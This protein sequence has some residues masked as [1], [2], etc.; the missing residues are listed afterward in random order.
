[1]INTK[2]MSKVLVSWLAF[3][4]DFLKNEQESFLGVDPN[5]THCQFYEH[6]YS[7]RSYDEHILLYSNPRQELWAEHLANTLKQINK[8]SK[9]S[10]R[11]LELKNVVGLDEIKP[12][13]EDLLL[14]LRE[15]EIEIFF[16]PGTSIM[17]LSWVF[18][19][20]TLRLNT[21]L[22]QTI[23][24]KHFDDK[25]PRLEE[26]TFENNLVPQTA[27]IKQQQ[28]EQSKAN[29]G[30]KLTPSIE[31]AYKRAE[32]VAQT[33][34]V[35]VFIRGESGTGKE[36]LARHVH[37]NSARRDAPFIPVNCAA[38]ADSLLESRLFGHKS[39]SFTGAEKDSKGYFEQAN[40]GTIFLDEIGHISPAMQ[41][42][43]LRVLQE[44]EIQPIGG[45]PKKVDVRVIAATN[46]QLEQMCKEGT[47]RWD[48]YYR[49]AVAELEL[50]TLCER[51]TAEVKTMLDHFVQQKRREFNKL[52]ELKF[53]KEAM[54]AILAYTYPGNIRELEN[55]IESLYVFCE[56]E[57]Q[58]EDLPKRLRESETEN[59][60][61]LSAAEKK[62][63]LK[64]FKIKNYNITH[65]KDALGIAPN[66]LKDRL[67]SYGLH[68]DSIIT[69]N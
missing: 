29:T 21:K 31:P 4:N 22:I 32:Q 57:V 50:P 58:L 1:L 64:V 2:N 17:Q 24:G 6:F 42:T 38:L 5:G 30:F 19:H 41:Q 67:K 7:A 28:V 49:L 52:K 26:L 47:F 10:P 18:C 9:V 25:Q 60:L 63:I 55:M 34:K 15:H 44:R 40:G 53:S 61:L 35:T 14:S 48:L 62:H 56:D 69:N 51:G 16:S 36:N 11:L 45:K 43:L 46:A 12:K 54:A 20:Q 59:T 23:A 8:N 68:G 33:D 37:H 3:K 65:T 39:G 13:V 27:V 66:T